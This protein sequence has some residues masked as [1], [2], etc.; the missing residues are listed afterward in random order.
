MALLGTRSTRQDW[1]SDQRL[2]QAANLVLERRSVAGADRVSRLQFRTRLASELA[3]IKR[4]VADGSYQ[5]TRYRQSL[6]P[7][8]AT[9]PPRELC[10]PTYRDRV[11]LR[12]LLGALQGTFGRAID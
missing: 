10:I 9:K 7:R 12:A 11:T 2:E 6:K 1:F 3:I 5:F 4:K 8:G